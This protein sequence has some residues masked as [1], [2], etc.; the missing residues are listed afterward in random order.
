MLC[1]NCG[2][3]NANAFGY[4]NSCGK[5]LTGVAAAPAAGFYPPPPPPK[6]LHLLGAIAILAMIGFALFVAANWAVPP[7]EKAPVAFRAGIFLGATIPALIVAFI[8]GGIKK[9]RSPN[10]FAVVF[11]LVGVTLSGMAWVGSLSEAPEDRVGRLMREASGQQPIKKDFWAADQKFDDIVREQFRRVIQLNHDYSDLGSK[12]NEDAISKVGAPESF[13]DP[14]YAA[15]GVRQLH[16]VA[17]LDQQLTLKLMEIG[18]NLRHAIDDT[19]WSASTKAKVHKGFE[20][21]FAES[22]QRRHGL[23]DAEEAYLTATD[24]L[25]EYANAHYADFRLVDGQLK[26]VNDSLLA[27]F[28]SRMQTYNARRND[29]IRVR[30]EFTRYQTA[31][32]S[33]LGVTPK[34]VGLH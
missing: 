27:D 34:D 17:L 8:A 33:R 22:L 14:T 2:R 24:N 26:T 4:C 29:L 23:S 30:E 5:P 16:E 28:N 1:P 20:S 31:T 18:N 3:D 7:D 15:E 21:G 19:D 12:I 10:R 11:L 6:K 9:W 13:V 25:Y 32:L